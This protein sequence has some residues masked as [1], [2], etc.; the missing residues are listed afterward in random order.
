MR[1]NVGIALQYLDAWL[2]GQGAVGIHNLMED[3][4]TAE[5]S[6]VQLWQ[7]IWN[8]ARLDDGRQLTA[9]LYRQI[10]DQELAA[11]GG[12][13]RGRLHDAAEILDRLVLNEK[14]EPFLT[15]P[16]YQYLD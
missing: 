13:G 9:D 7:W 8:D 5:I 16:A 4:A 2:Q 10:R 14:L 12:P 11:L 1:A 15:I 6:R 3:T